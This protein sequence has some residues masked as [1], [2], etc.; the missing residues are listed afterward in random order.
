MPDN[1]ICD[2]E[3]DFEYEGK[4]FINDGVE[5][6]TLARGIDGDTAHFYTQDGTY[7]KVRFLGVNT[8]ESTYEEEPW[9]KEAS[10]FTSQI[11]YN[12]KTIV[13]ESEGNIKDTHGRYLAFVWADG[14]L[15]NLELIQNGY[16]NSK[17]SSS[18]KYFD[19]FY[20]T[21]Y[22]ISLTGR[23]IWGEIDPGCDYENNEFK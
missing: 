7:I 17:L 21:E 22:A 9:G 15:V 2:V 3:M 6:V 11:L 23:K 1:N 14:V 4:T 10:L 18:S 16:S 20:E 19:A 8:P 12:A 13:I 5:K